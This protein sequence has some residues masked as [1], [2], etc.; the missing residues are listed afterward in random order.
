M[1]V[2]MIGMCAVGVVIVGED[3]GEWGSEMGP[4]QGGSAPSKGHR[5][6][7]LGLSRRN[8]DSGILQLWIGDCARG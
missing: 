7:N 1:F 3:G 5:A 8:S 6:N 2:G 4:G